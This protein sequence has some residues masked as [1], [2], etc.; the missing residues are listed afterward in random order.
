M[1]RKH[2]LLLYRMALVAILS[3][4]GVVLMLYVKLPYPFASWCEIEISDL[5]VVVGYVLTGLPGATAIAVVKTL[6]HLLVM[7]THGFGGAPYVGDLAAL[8]SSLLYLLG[9]FLA[10]HVL[11]L[12][13][14]GFRM[15]LLGY[16][17][18]ALFV[19]IAMTFLNLLFIT[20]SFLAPQYTTCF[21]S[22]AVLGVEQTLGSMGFPYSYA[23]II[24]AVYIPFNLL[25]SA[26]IL[27]LYEILFNALFFHLLKNN[28]VLG[29][30]TRSKDVERRILTRGLD[31]REEEGAT[32]NVHEKEREP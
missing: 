20:P 31:F 24:F 13:R 21:D 18:L 6:I 25:K 2:S 5:T 10:S 23:I 32:M 28:A 22:E 29:E 17:L 27:A 9:I 30:L 14:K 16:L 4:L 15:R 26:L 7:P 12:F 3:A 11:H 1:R 8:F 19:S